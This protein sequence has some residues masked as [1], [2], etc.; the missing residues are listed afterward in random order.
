VETKKNSVLFGVVVIAFLLVFG[1]LIKDYNMKRFNDFKT[2]EFTI[3]KIVNLNN[4]RIKTLSDQIVALERENEDL[5]STLTNTRNGL[6]TLSK[7]LAEAS[8]V[9]VPSNA[10]VAATAST[11][12][13]V[14]K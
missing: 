4:D 14:T 13:T 9:A 3:T 8:P 10:P 5:R 6:E 11:P 1:L 2:Y 12:A 7:K